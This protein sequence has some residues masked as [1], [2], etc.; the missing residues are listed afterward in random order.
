MKEL[1]AWPRRSVAIKI[2]VAVIGPLA[3]IIGL[4]TNLLLKLREQWVYEQFHH[5]RQLLERSLVDRFGGAEAA[6]HRAAM[7]EILTD[8]RRTAPLY[9][10]R[11]IGAADVV[12]YSTRESEVGQSFGGFATQTDN[13]QH[14]RALTPLACERSCRGCHQTQEGP[15]GVLVIDYP[16]EQLNAVVRGERISL[17][18]YAV[19]VLVMIGGVVLLLI[20]T[21]I[22]NPLSALQRAIARVQEGDLTARA[23][24]A[25]RDQFRQLAD[26]FNAMVGSLATQRA[27]LENL[28][29]RQLAQADRLA[30]VGKLASG[31]AHEIKNPLHGVTS[32]LAVV[33]DRL[34]EP[35][36]RDIVDEMQAQLKRVVV[37][38]EDMLKYARPSK[39]E[40][41]PCHLAEVLDRVLLLLQSDFAKRGVQVVREIPG[42]L[43]ALPLDSAKLQ[44]VLLN[45]LLNAAQAV[46]LGGT[47]FVRLQVTADGQTMVLQVEDNGPGIGDEQARHLFEPFFTTKLGG[48]GLGLP[49]TRTL[50]EQHQGTIDL[51]RGAIGG[52]CFEVRLPITLSREPQP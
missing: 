21:I 32:A 47:V 25:G 24:V 26:G 16:Q 44:Q 33:R 52:A 15:L 12:A 46:P 20:W 41:Q 37:I 10:L 9:T 34:P 8:F 19:A 3:L 7:E 4:Y 1:L 11:L 39:P 49:I 51:V 14:L 31:L 6:G 5:T 43:P 13:G 23:V 27:E 17:V 42:D 35:N 45:L 38:V 28:H 40:L 36:L 2:M 50:V 30:S 18:K 22:L 29:Q 48:N